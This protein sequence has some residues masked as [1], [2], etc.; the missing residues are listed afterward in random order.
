MYFISLIILPSVETQEKRLHVACECERLCLFVE[1][2][3]DSSSGLFLARQ[4]ANSADGG[5]GW[6]ALTTPLPCRRDGVR[7]TRRDRE[8]LSVK[9]GEKKRTR[10]CQLTSVSRIIAEIISSK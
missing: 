6:A 2:S 3:S 1:G 7:R 5:F 4:T 10:F 9:R 8:S